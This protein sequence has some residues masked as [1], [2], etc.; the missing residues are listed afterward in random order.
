MLTGNNGLLTKAALAKEAMRG[1]EVQEYIN[2]AL[3]ENLIYKYT[4]GNEK[5]KNDV[6]DELRKRGKLTKEEEELLKDKNV[7]NIGGIK[8]DFARTNIRRRSSRT[9]CRVLC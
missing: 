3:N 6:I 1:G 2:L 5:T 7:I 4:N 9:M 8:V